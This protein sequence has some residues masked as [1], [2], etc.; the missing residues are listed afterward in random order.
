MTVFT[1]PSQKQL[2]PTERLDLRFVRIA[3]PNQVFGIAV[4]D[5]H[6]GWWDVNCVSPGGS[7]SGSNSCLRRIQTHTMGKE[8]TEHESVVGLGVILGKS[9]VLIHVER[10]DILESE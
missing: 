8:F 10:E 6:L 4:Q 9:D 2:N 5:V 3:F 7:V 1:D